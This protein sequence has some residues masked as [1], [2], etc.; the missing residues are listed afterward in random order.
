MLIFRNVNEVLRGISQGKLIQCHTCK[1][2]LTKDDLKKLLENGYICPLCG[3]R[4]YKK[5]AVRGE[6]A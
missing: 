3:K 4:I 2:K 1:E 5:Y 6:R